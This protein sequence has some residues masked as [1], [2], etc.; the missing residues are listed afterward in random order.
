MYEINIKTLFKDI[1]VPSLNT[2]TLLKLCASHVSSRPYFNKIEYDVS[3]RC[4]K[5]T[6]TVLFQPIVYVYP[7]RYTRK[8]ADLQLLIDH[9]FLYHA[10]EFLYVDEDISFVEGEYR[11]IFNATKS[12]RFWT[13]L[14]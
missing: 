4:C 1:T 13:K 8:Q 9:I 7:D 11:Y 12:K 3:I 14:S 10:Q 5:N 6:Y 2:I